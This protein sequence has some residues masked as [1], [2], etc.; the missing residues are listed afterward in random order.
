MTYRIVHVEHELVGG[1]PAHRHIV[2]VGTGSDPHY[3]QR[4]WML[5]ELLHAREHGDEF[6]TLGETSQHIGI[7]ERYQCSDCGSW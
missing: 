7:V 5:D 3:V 4:R 6:Y 1:S 2:A